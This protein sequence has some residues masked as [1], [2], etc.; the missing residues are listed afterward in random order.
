MRTFEWNPGFG[1]GLDDVDRQHRRLVDLISELSGRLEREPDLEPATL[2]AMYADLVDYSRYHFDTEEKLMAEAGVDP[3]HVLRHTREHEDFARHVRETLARPADDA[4]GAAPRRLLEFLVHWLTYHILGSDQSM[5]RQLEALRAG[6][7]AA[8]AFDG[9]ERGGD[10][11]TATLLDSVHALFALLSER[12]RQLVGLAESLERRVAERTAALEAA[13]AELAALV[14]R[15]ERTAVTDALTGL[16]NRR[17]ATQ[18]LAQAWHLS[19]RYGHP[20]SC[21]VVDADGFK[22]VNDRW[23]HEAGDRVLEALAAALKGSVRAGDDVCRVGGDEFLVLAPVTDLQGA[24]A[25]GERVRASVARLRVP[26][27]SGVWRGSVS[28]GAAARHP[29]LDGVEALLREADRGLYA[30]KRAGRNAVRAAEGEA[31][32]G[33]AGAAAA[34]PA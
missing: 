1:T 32:A 17:Y 21:L 19:V 30:A 34:A 23:G 25:L 11:A 27:G 18:R 26:A 12:N 28:V 5:A 16:P 24:L 6:A 9:G 2:A 3:R 31:A 7:T 4:A 14:E 15:V 10:R 20:L 29:G 33:A 22:E 8:Q 13:N